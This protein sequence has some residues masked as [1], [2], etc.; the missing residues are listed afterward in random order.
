M[1]GKFSPFSSQSLPL[2]KLNH[3]MFIIH[4]IH[5]LLKGT[6]SV[7]MRL[8]SRDLLSILLN[9]I[10]EPSDSE[11]DHLIHSTACTKIFSSRQLE[12]SHQFKYLKHLIKLL[13]VELFIVIMI[14]G[15]RDSYFYPIRNH[16]TKF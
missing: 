8:G 11:F 13:Y 10:Q 4:G 3:Q 7:I 15:L 1:R 16:P 6:R 2:A 5:F 14:R 12:S 9:V